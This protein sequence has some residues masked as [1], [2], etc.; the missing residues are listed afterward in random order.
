MTEVALREAKN[1]LSELIERKR[2]LEAALTSKGWSRRRAG[3]TCYEAPGAAYEHCKA[4][5]TSWTPQNEARRL[6]GLRW[7]K[8]P[9]EVKA[10]KSDERR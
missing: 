8:R 2:G 10:W 7:P 5:R 4:D 9:P 3:T 6:F 1:R